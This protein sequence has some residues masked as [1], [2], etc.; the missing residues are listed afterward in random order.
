MPPSLEFDFFYAWPVYFKSEFQLR[1]KK[2]DSAAS[3]AMMDRL[4]PELVVRVL[5]QLE[6]EHLSRCDQLSRRFHGLTSIAE[7]ALGLIMHIESD[8]LLQERFHL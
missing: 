2:V 1:Y 8:E 3:R 5:M 7:K 4:P 6:P